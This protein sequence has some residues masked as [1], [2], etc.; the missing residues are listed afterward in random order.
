MA[1]LEQKQDLT[2]LYIGYFDRAPDPAGL[3]F[4]IDQIDNG[5]EFNTIAA[6]FASSDEAEA[7]YPFLTTP[8]VSTP[9]AF[10]TS[11]YVNL[12]GRPPEQEGLDFWT[13]V[14][15]NGSVSAGDMVEA[16]IMGARDDDDLGTSDKSVLDNK[17]EVGLDWVESVGN[18]PGFEFDAAAKAAAVA[19]VNG[20]TEDEATVE[21]AKEAT[22]AY[23]DGESN[24]GVGDNLTLTDAIGEQVVGTAGNDT[25]KAVLDGGVV[26]GDVGTANIGDEV[27]GGAG[28]DTFNVIV[29]DAAGGGTI[30]AGFEVSNMEVINLTYATDGDNLGA[31]SSSSFGGVEELWQIDNTA[32]SD[33]FQNVTVAADVTA[34]FRSTGATAT[35][36]EATA[37]NTVTAASGSQKTIAVAFDGVDTGSG[38]TFVGAGLETA[39]VS[40]NVAGTGS[41][42]AMTGVANI[43][44]L[45]LG[46]TDDTTVTL[47]TFGGVTA[48]DAS[49]S[50]GGFTL[51][52]SGLA[53]LET[54]TGGSAGESVTFDV[55]QGND[56]AIDMGAGNDTAVLTGT[57]AAANNASTI[58]LGAGEDT[59]DIN[60]IANISDADEADF[61]DGLITVAD[62]NTSND[63][64]DVA[65]LATARLATLTEQSNIAAETSLFDAV[66][67][68]A[69]IAG[70]NGELVFQY[71]N[72]S[73]VFQNDAQAAFDSGDGLVKLTGVSMD[74]FNA[75]NFVA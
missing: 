47:T 38:A 7:L 34:G 9:D 46:I 60:A 66:T 22:D 13:D 16:I 63:V 73:Y 45:N 64:L 32:G 62:F 15:E 57:A 53:A 65:T 8:G 30:P 20:V 40:G 56:V 41:T 43:E 14:L 28:R 52:A 21:A 23:V 55:E 26:A 18:K 71:G 51:D 6:D 48:V 5:R 54:Y 35:A 69:G 74:D 37:T 4:W 33:D 58:T 27:D 67:T 70:A 3:Q 29:T 10:V 12:F 31:L 59:L 42:L 24:P 25:F 72:D 2:A 39:T 11:I 36:A 49:S 1:T 50:T 75:V 68:A 44:T 17:I 19:S 61:E